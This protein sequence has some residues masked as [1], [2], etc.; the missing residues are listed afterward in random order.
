MKKLIAVLLLAALTVSLAACASSGNVSKTDSAAE[1]SSPVSTAA[2][3]DDDDPTVIFDFSTCGANGNIIYFCGTDGLYA[4][5]GDSA[6][7]RLASA[8]TSFYYRFI[9]DIYYVTESGGESCELH[10]VQ[11]DGTKDKKLYTFDKPYYMV[12]PV[13][14]RGN[15]LIFNDGDLQRVNLKTGKAEVLAKEQPTPVYAADRRVFYITD[16]TSAAL[17]CF[18]IDQKTETTVLK[19]NGTLTVFDDNGKL[20]AVQGND[21]AAT[22][23][24]I[25][26]NNKAQKLGGVSA[27]DALQI[28]DFKGGTLFYQSYNG[29]DGAFKTFILRPGEEPE[30]VEEI[31]YKLKGLH[32][33]EQPVFAAGSTYLVYDKDSNSFSA[34]QKPDEKAELQ[35]CGKRCLYT[36]FNAEEGKSEYVT[37]AKN[38]T[39]GVPKL[40]EMNSVAPSSP[41][42]EYLRLKKLYLNKDGYIFRIPEVTIDTSAAGVINRELYQTTSLYGSYYKSFEPSDGCFSFYTAGAGDNSLRN[43]SLYTL[44]TS[45]GEKLEQGDMLAL[46]TYNT[47]NFYMELQEELFRQAKDVYLH[48]STQFER[49]AENRPEYKADVAEIPDEVYGQAVLSAQSNLQLAYLGDNTVLC[50]ARFR[51]RAGAE[52]GTHIFTFTYRE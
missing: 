15:E 19:A 21:K 6:P 47:T 20:Y 22:L 12:T 4:F 34:L 30:E 28:V 33:A 2:D 32:N 3:D 35:F 46:V 5:D 26:D 27:D 9:D 1:G 8:D 29:T 25:E 49:D 18:D 14:R 44:N 50:A 40:E 45:T 51:H 43:Y 13:L 52:S 10:T 38:L 42:S 41:D 31:N 11:V 39:P 23:Y 7:K 48:A 37:T 17:K 24:A 16:E 36:V